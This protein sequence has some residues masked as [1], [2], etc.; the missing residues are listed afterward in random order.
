MT[1]RARV[2]QALSGGWGVIL[3][4]VMIFAI[5]AAGVEMDGVVVSTDRNVARYAFEDTSASLKDAAE[6]VTLFGSEGVWV[7]GLSMGALLIVRR[8]WPELATGLGAV[9]GGKLVNVAL[10]ELFARPRPIYEGQIVSENAYSFPSG[11]A[12]MSLIAYGLLVVLLLRWG[13]PD[14]W[15]SPLIAGVSVLVI[16]IG[17]SRMV[18]GV[19][20]LTDVVGGFA[21]G[22]A[23]LGVWVLALRGMDRRLAVAGRAP[24]GEPASDR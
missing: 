7:V 1:Q 15:R 10:K 3:A 14:R 12:M 6:V 9:A 21:A 5:L 20:Y 16:L 8:R 2:T 19:H 4:C 22:A 24:L 13:V 11:H 17:A 18:L 23:W